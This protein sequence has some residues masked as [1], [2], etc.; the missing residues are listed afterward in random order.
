MEI[1]VKV[2]KGCLDAENDAQARNFVLYS[3][4][5]TIF[6]LYVAILL[7]TVNC[8]YVEILVMSVWLCCTDDHRPGGCF[9]K[10]LFRGGVFN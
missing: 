8:A 1:G 9:L 6:W 7:P 4:V 10:L 3:T 5:H 2:T